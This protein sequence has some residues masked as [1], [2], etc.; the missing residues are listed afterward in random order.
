MYAGFT[1]AL[2]RE[3]SRLGVDVRA[4]TGV[5]RGDGLAPDLY[6]GRFGGDYPD[7]D[8][9]MGPLD[10]TQGSFRNVTSSREIDALAARG[11]READARLRQAI[12][13]DIEEL[14]AREALIIPLFH[15]N[16]YCFTRPEVKGMDEEFL[17]M[18]IGTDYARLWVE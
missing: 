12:Y 9:F 4:E 18:T 1:Q 5:I 15:E 14:I 16:R 3:L 6:L 8:T 10:S 2:L 7:P 17:R 11:R 13:R